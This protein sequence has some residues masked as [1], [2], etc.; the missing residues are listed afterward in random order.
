MVAKIQGNSV[1]IHMYGGKK[2]VTGK[3]EAL[4]TMNDIRK[5]ISKIAAHSSPTALQGAF[6]EVQ[7][8]NRNSCLITTYVGR[9]LKDQTALVRAIRLDANIAAKATKIESRILV[10][11]V[12]QESKLA[13]NKPK[14]APSLFSK[15]RSVFTA[16]R[17]LVS[18]K[19]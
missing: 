5:R 12:E 16:F 9:V 8:L 14:A 18:F 17:Q 4:A 11:K 2:T 6:E 10:A 19:K 1:V 7:E 13:K 15:I 3:D